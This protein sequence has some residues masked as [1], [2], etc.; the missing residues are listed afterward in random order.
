M[1]LNLGAGGNPLAH[2]VNL[3]S[4]GGWLFEDGLGDYAAGG[5]EGITIS[6]ALMYVELADWSATFREFYR[7]LEPGGIVRITEDDTE[8]PESER[9]GGWHDHRTL[10]G[11]LVVRV[12]LRAA[13]FKTRAQTATSTGFCD[14]SLLQAWHGDEPK[15]FFLEGRKP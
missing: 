9:F 4:D 6:H 5:V 1:I 15:V 2:A 7:V 12:H 10:T 13:G 3:D 14:G 11:P 8:D